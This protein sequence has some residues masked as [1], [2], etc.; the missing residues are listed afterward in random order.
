MNPRPDRPDAA[1]RLISFRHTRLFKRG[2]WLSAVT[3]YASAVLQS[4]PDGRLALPDA[5][6]LLTLG[7]LAAALAYGLWTLQIH[8]LADEVQDQGERFLIRRGRTQIIV[9]AALIAAAEVAMVGGMPRI[10]LRLR[11]RGR[12]GE[13]LAFLPPASLWSNRR[14][15]ERLARE[16]ALR[17]EGLRPQ[18]GAV[19]GG[20]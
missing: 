2:L 16:L 18:P 3:L 1:W 17:A 15:L 14:A 9:P 20:R 6:H 19:G 13:R 8:R 4:L 7:L 11:T 12:L 10:S 5:G